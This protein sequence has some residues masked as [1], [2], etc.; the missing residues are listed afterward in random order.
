MFKFKLPV[1]DNDTRWMS[2]FNMLVSCLQCRIFCE[3]EQYYD[4]ENSPSFSESEYKEVEEIVEAL[5]PL[6]IITL[7]FQKEQLTIPCTALAWTRAKTLLR[8]MSSNIADM[9]YQ[10]MCIREKTLYS[11]IAFLSALYLDPRTNVLVPPQEVRKVQDHL[12]FLSLKSQ[13]LKCQIALEET[14]IID[15]EDGSSTSL[16]NS[17]TD[18]L[19]EKEMQEIEK[20]RTRDRVKN[21][22]DMFQPGVIEAQIKEFANTPR[23]NSNENVLQFW[24]TKKNIQPGLYALAQIVL[25]APPTQVSVE[26][27]FSGLKFILHPLRNGMSADNVNNVM[28][29]RTNKLFLLK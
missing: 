4:D 6:Q 7:Q 5:E 9:L 2:T 16:Q 22:Y 28:L 1:L 19:L 23:S 12:L 17:T 8:G 25:A 18:D 27:L 26:R 14:E 21:K 29:V 11:Q 24:E 20:Q 13:A 10:A 15:S 3:D